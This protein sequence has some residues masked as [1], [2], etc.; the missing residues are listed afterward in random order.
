[1][2]EP[3]VA[4]SRAEYPEYHAMLTELFAGAARIMVAHDSAPS[5][6][7]AAEIGRGLVSGPACLGMLAGRA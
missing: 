3:Q 7:A 6:I 4:Y 2:N 5:L 1:M